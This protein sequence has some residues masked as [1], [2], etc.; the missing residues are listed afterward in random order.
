M[1]K[2]TKKD[3]YE[4]TH[5]NLVDVMQEACTHDDFDDYEPFE[6][7]LSF[8][9]DDY[10]QEFDMHGVE[11]PEFYSGGETPPECTNAC[12]IV[13]GSFLSVGI[14]E[15]D[16][17]DGVDHIINSTT[18]SKG[19]ANAFKK[20]FSTRFNKVAAILII[21]LLSINIIM[22]ATDSI[23]SYGSK[24]LLHRISSS[25]LGVFTDSNDVDD[26][27]VV[28]EYY[29]TTEEEVNNILERFP[30]T[31]VPQY[32][33]EGYSFVSMDVK[34]MAS[35]DRWMNYTYMDDNDLFTIDMSYAADETARVFA[36][37]VI[38]ESG[39][40]IKMSDRIICTYLD[41]IQKK[42]VSDIYFNDCMMDISCM[43]NK[44][45]IIKIAKC[46]EKHTK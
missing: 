31:Y 42:F 28:D 4:K 10:D 44:E 32:I 29:A 18:G 38:D 2:N 17:N 14:S 35:G 16:T 26:A 11:I 15:N 8:M 20:H 23:D 22:M 46:M 34:C 21:A 25:V 3:L 6:L 41:T 5:I 27:Q 19:I 39:V 9:E 7:D 36:P 37:N 43:D 33:P 24:G 12:E 40:I 13:N 30:D 1:I 45:D